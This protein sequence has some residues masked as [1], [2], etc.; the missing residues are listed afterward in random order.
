MLSVE[1]KRE[2]RNWFLFLIGYFAFGYLFINWINQ[3]RTRYFDV[4]FTFED[5]IPFV[6]IFILGYTLVYFSMFLL[7]MIIDDMEDMHRAV[8]ACLLMTSVH[9]LFFLALPV[10]FEERPVLQGVEGF[11][12][13]L[14]RFY[15]FI[16]KPQ[17]CFPSLH[18]AYPTMASLISWRNHRRWSFAF[19]FMTIIIAVSVVLVKQHYIMDVVGGALTATLSYVIVVRAEPRWKRFFRPSNIRRA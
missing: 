18:I 4:S 14:T 1:Q 8:M 17:N 16:D 13:G 5:S 15:Y 3:F 6:P 19:V 9:Y 12:A 11:G 2:K 7:Y 10:R